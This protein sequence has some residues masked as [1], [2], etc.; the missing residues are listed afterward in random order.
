MSA[1]LMAVARHSPHAQSGDTVG[2]KW[3]H[4]EQAHTGG[5]PDGESRGQGGKGMLPL[6]AWLS[7]G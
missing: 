7:R 3:G 1:L 4:R 6:R 2:T 5:Q